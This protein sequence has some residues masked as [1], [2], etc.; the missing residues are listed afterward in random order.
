[1]NKTPL[2]TTAPKSLCMLRLSAIGDV[3]H[4]IAVAQSIEKEWPQT[5]LT[6]IIG[7]IEAQLLKP[8][9]PNIHFIV[10]DKKKGWREYLRVWK[11]L[12]HEDFSA[13]LHMQAAIRASLLAL[14]IKAPYKLGFDKVRVS[15]KQNWFTN[16]K[17]PSPASPHVADGFMAFAHTLGIKQQK[18]TWNICIPKQDLE[19]A[20][21]AVSIP[22]DKRLLVI[23]PAA[24]KA[25]KNWTAQGYVDVIRYAQ[26]HHFHV[27]LAGSPHPIE[28]TLGKDIETLLQGSQSIVNNLIGKTNLM[29]MLALLKQAQL[30]ISPDSGPAH[31]ASIVDTP[32]IG[33]YAHHDPKRVGPYNYP[34]LCVSIYQQLAEKAE[35]KPRS[36]L[37]WRYRVKDPH[38]M[39]HIRS[40]Q[41]IS[42]LEK[43]INKEE[44]H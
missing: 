18:P 3:T 7:K 40:H 14:G 4:A 9:L 2:F 43:Q 11:L 37:S 6:W 36:Q 5:K 29:Q 31:M 30:V 19:W 24:S 42:I 12:K 10:F 13:L 33:L 28:V 26:Q 39:Q 35:G 20:Q 27:V 44:I 1:M 23:A 16:I 22:T 38:A 41:V 15:D 34:E 21:K 8:L 25:F 17:V 32:V